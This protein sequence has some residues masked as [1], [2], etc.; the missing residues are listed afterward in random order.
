MIPRS[1]TSKKAPFED[2]RVWQ[3][4]QELAVAVYGITAR[5]PPAERYGLSAQLRRAAVSISANIAEGNARR[6][7]REYI[8]AC[9]VARGSIA[10]TK[11]LLNL[12]VRLGYVEQTEYD[13]LL[14][15]YSQTGRMLQ[16]LIERLAQMEGK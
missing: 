2:L 12:A 14:E 5:F 8:Q 13:A 6:F 7:R 15:G 3:A 11:A 10:E 4:A 1:T 16:R 9:S